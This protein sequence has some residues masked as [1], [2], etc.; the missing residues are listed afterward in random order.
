MADSIETNPLAWK[1]KIDLRFFVDTKENMLKHSLALIA[2]W[3]VG[4]EL[5]WKVMFKL[6]PWW[7]A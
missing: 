1:L 6:P 3:I 7:N 4:K 2:L 5:T